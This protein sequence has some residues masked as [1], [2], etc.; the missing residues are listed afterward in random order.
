MVESHL[1]ERG[2]SSV[3][4]IFSLPN[5][6]YKVYY[7]LYPRNIV[8]MINIIGVDYWLIGLSCFDS[9]SGVISVPD[10]IL[11]SFCHCQCKISHMLSCAKSLMYIILSWVHLNVGNETKLKGGC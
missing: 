5:K 6:L 3:S 2:I 7:A 10:I 9:K 8:L 4:R 1:S 11:C